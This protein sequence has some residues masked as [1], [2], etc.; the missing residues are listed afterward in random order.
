MARY[1]I[2]ESE[3]RNMV[4][5]AINE[6]EDNFINIDPDAGFPDEECVIPG[7]EN[8]PRFAYGF[9]SDDENEVANGIAGYGWGDPD[10]FDKNID[11]Q[12]SWNA[13][14]NFYGA[15]DTNE[16]RLRGI[17][18]NAVNEAI[19]DEGLGLDMWGSNWKD[20][21]NKVK[22][23]WN[24]KYDMPNR[25]EVRNF[26]HTGHPDGEDFDYYDA[27]EQGMNFTNTPHN[28]DTNSANF[29]NPN[30]R[31]NKGLWG[32]I[33]RATSVGL[34][35]ALK[36]GGKR[37]RNFGNTIDRLTNDDEIDNPMNPDY[38]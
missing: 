8:D 31:I 22:D 5:R 38:E 35:T 9:P 29:G 30:K 7:Y 13:I 17:I 11:N 18:R 36:N 6:V 4:R 26:I 19:M 1:I 28:N 21:W 24:G 32:K 25:E 27:D 3:L 33:G 37:Y 2:K 20:R 16:N 14:D 12:M 10:D 15:Q 23:T 34:A